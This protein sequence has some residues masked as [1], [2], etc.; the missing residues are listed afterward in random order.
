MTS[1]QL[2]PLLAWGGLIAWVFAAAL[3]WRRQLRL[4]GALHALLAL[5]IVV[6]C[7]LTLGAWALDPADYAR[8]NGAAALGELR[9]DTALFALG[10]IV[11]AAGALEWRGRRW[12]GIAAALLTAGFL[13]LLFY[14]AYFFRIF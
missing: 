9:F 11:L 6:P 10:L 13:A 7:A 3:L 4:A 1:D 12:A 8:R 2:L 5:P 14:F